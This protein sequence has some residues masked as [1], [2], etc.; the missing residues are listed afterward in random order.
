MT[1]AR[2]CVCVFMRVRTSS[3]PQRCPSSPPAVV[4][5]SRLAWP[6]SPPSSPSGFCPEFHLSARESGSARQPS[7]AGLETQTHGETADTTD[8]QI[9]FIHTSTEG[10]ILLQSH[11][12]HL[13][14]NTSETTLVFVYSE[15]DGKASLQIPLSVF[16]MHCFYFACP[17]SIQF[18][19]VLFI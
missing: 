10:K 18:D 12:Q 1:C 11:F 6:G 14:E 5:S 4:F 3:P 15:N 9:Q 2:V 16:V 7:T 8:G 17:V 13:L 19:S